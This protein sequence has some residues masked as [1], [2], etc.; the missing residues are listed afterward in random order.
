MKK[1]LLLMS[2]LIGV[3]LWLKRDGATSKGDEQ[4]TREKGRSP[5]KKGDRSGEIR[6]IESPMFSEGYGRKGGSYENDLLI[7]QA[8][9]FDMP[10]VD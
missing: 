6:L 8:I 7:L 3:F 10:N 4:S 2:L 5:E 9:V 1:I